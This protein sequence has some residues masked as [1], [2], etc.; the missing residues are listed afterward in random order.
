MARAIDGPDELAF[1]R[2]DAC[3]RT[4]GPSRDSP[5]T[6][7]DYAAGPGGLGLGRFLVER[8]GQ[9]I[10]QR[11]HDQDQE[12]QPGKDLVAEP[13][14]LLRLLVRR[15]VLG[16]EVAVLAEDG[17]EVRLLQRLE[18]ALRLAAS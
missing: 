4:T 15:G 5:A 3:E 10:L 9:E 1:S 18:L 17:V 11:H 12:H 7:V 16:Q 2:G 6:T 8:V 14:E 13:R